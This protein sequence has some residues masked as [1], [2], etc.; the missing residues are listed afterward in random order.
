MMFRIVGI[1]ILIQLGIAQQVQEGSPYS[2]L[3]GL[4]N[5]YHI[6]DLPL[7]DI[8]ALLEEDSNRDNGTPYRYGYQHYV[9]LSTEN[10][11]IWE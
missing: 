5:N 1:L 9:E 6:I 4:D 11:G 3:Q 8:E 2:R 7:V 10:S